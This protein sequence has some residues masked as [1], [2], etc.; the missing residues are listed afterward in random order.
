[1]KK[2]DSLLEKTVL[3]GSEQWKSP[4]LLEKP[5]LTSSQRW[6]SRFFTWNPRFNP[7]RTLKKSILYLKNPIL[8]S[9]EHWRSQ[10]FTWKT[11]LTD[12]ECWKNQFFT[13]KKNLNR[14]RGAEVVGILL[15]PSFDHFVITCLDRSRLWKGDQ[16]KIRFCVICLQERL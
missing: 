8:T 13:Y 11:V 6:K 7:F 4:F 14:F 2:V 5:V 12:S 10:F 15:K 3:T 16:E 1:M 9:S